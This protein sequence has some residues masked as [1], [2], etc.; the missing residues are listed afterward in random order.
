MITLQHSLCDLIKLNGSIDK[1]IKEVSFV[2]LPDAIRAYLGDRQ[3][4]HFEENPDND[5]I[6]WYQFP[7][8]YFNL[9]REKALKFPKHLAYISKKSCLGEKSHIEEFLKRNENL[10]LNI[11]EGILTHLIQD[12]FYDM[13]VR[14]LISFDNKYEPNAVFY[15][16]GLD[17]N[18]DQIRKIIFELEE[19]GFYLL[20]HYCYE[21][22]G[23]ITNQEW[24]D[25]VVKK[26]LDNEFP[27]D[28]VESTYKY[29]KIN[30]KINEWITNKDWS[31]LGFVKKYYKS[32]FKLYNKVEY[33]TKNI[34]L[35][36]KD[37]NNK[38]FD[39]KNF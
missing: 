24:F 22:Y 1:F 38:L 15:F 37:Y 20:A 8:E 31:H 27:K 18:S 9:T 7:M 26:A 25:K 2:L 5:D 33:Y 23:I 39:Y 4:S 12:Y 35:F 29:M 13:W 21:K 3:L 6:S 10:P 11:K 17:Y 32:Y 34:D 30:Q 19:Y 16:Q 36:I 28:L 14:N